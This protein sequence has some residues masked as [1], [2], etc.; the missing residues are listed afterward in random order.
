MKK[1]ERWTR[2]RVQEII[3]YQKANGC[4]MKETCEHFNVNAS[5]FYSAMNRLKNG[6]AKGKTKVTRIPAMMTVDIP[7]VASALLPTGHAAVVV[8]PIGQVQ[9]FVRSL[10]Q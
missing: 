2:G 4:S 7:D 8:M 9:Q 3:D 10:W 5:T 6:K 1:R